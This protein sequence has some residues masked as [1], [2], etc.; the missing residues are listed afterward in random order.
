[1]TN[2]IN[3]IEE[4]DCIFVIGS[5]TTVAHPIIAHKVK[6]AVK[7]GVKLIVASP[8]EIDLC[9][10]AHVY[11]Q[12]LPGTDVALLM[13]M[14]K[15]II[16]ENLQ[17]ESFIRHRCEDY[18]LLKNSLDG[19]DLDFVETTTRVPREK[20]IQAAKI[21][22]QNSPASILYAMGITQH[23]HGTDNVSA[24]ANLALLTGNIGKK[25]S[26]VNPLRGQ[27]NV[28]GA[29]DMG[30]LPDVYPGYQKV[31]MP[32]IHKK[33]ETAWNTSL[34]DIPGKTHT[35]I[36]D[37]I[38]TRKIKALYVIGENPVLSE[39]DA[40]HVKQA[41]KKLNFLVVQDIFLS[42]TA[43][44]ADVVLPATT[45]AEKNGTFTNT[46]RRVQL[47]RKAIAS[48]G[49]AKS[50]DWIINE[51]A[52]RMGAK[53]FEHQPPDRIM[54]EIASV[55]PSYGGIS[56]ARLENETLQWPCP[57][58]DH[59]GTAFLHRGKFP[60]PSGKGKFVPLTYKPP[61]ELPDKT[62]PFILTTG[63]S[64]YHF[65]TATM[66][67][68]VYG[69][70]VLRPGEYVEINPEDAMALGIKTGTLVRVASRRGQ[71]Q[72]AAHITDLCA[73]GVI[74]MTFHFAECP[75]NE[76]TNCVV[77]PVAKIPETKVCAVSV[78]KI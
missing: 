61:A 3:P 12:L 1:M 21:Y 60:T 42:E 78:E 70:T 71:V 57:H 54:D 53:G 6:Y 27:N 35:E 37:A 26:G 39:A 9:E 50:D 46:E 68:K 75:T 17:N 10:N 19:I 40:N 24:I 28:Q 76:L 72:A 32:G 14:M 44:M 62:Y 30:G 13:G 5:N 31:D 7:K 33:F 16:G 18:D 64:L 22:A 29:C 36:I 43:K 51:I 67:R 2:S 63:R 34:N 59:P 23:S 73:K 56:H 38:D 66:S 52:T 65:H 55:T 69:L 45:F 74:N 8:I 58:K 77:D 41:L 48:I 49:E 47:I 4:A 11:L 20:V 15:V 25:S